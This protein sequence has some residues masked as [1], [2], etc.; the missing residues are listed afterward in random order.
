MRTLCILI[1]SIASFTTANAQGGRIQLAGD[2]GGLTCEFTN[3]SGSFNFVYQIH[4][5]SPGTTLSRYMLQPSNAP[6]FIWVFDNYLP[7]SAIGSAPLGVAVA[8]GACKAS[9]VVIGHSGY[10][11]LDFGGCESLR[12]VP[13]PASTSGTIESIDCSLPTPLKFVAV[14]SV[15]TYKVLGTYVCRPAAC[16]QIIPVRDTSWGRIKALYEQD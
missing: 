9:P 7:H 11:M 12:V 10:T 1:I 5:A 6:S 14:G 15:L 3:A 8:Y 2:P 4:Q 16:G 13:D